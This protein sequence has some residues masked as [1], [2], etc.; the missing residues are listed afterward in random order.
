MNRS[1]NI[2]LL[3]LVAMFLVVLLHVNS[4]GGLL[5]AYYPKSDPFCF[6]TVN[7]VEYISLIAVNSYLFISGYFLSASVR[8]FKVGKLLHLLLTTVFWAWLIGGSAC[9]FLDAPLDDFL[10]DGIFPML[11][12]RYWFVTPYLILYFLSPYYNQTLQ[13]LDRRAHR[14]LLGFLLFF[15]SL[16]PLFWDPLGLKGGYS[17]YWFSF[18][19]ILA[20]YIRKYPV[21]HSVRTLLLVW[22]G[23]LLI[24]LSGAYFL[25]LNGRYDL[26]NQFF[27][28]NYNS[29]FIL[30]NT[31]CCFLLFRSIRI[32]RGQALIRFLAPLTFGIYLVHIHPA[33]ASWIYQEFL[34][35]REVAGRSPWTVLV[36]LFGFALLVF[37]VSALLEYCRSRLFVAFRVEERIGRVMR[38]LLKVKE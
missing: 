22:A 25:K 35:V 28:Q 12:G 29:P 27:G 17:L 5:K 38:R 8:P 36:S 10:S 19:Y 21:R 18:I 13:R 37:C 24:Q 16:A 33:T 20:A 31:V 14:L 3:R 2:E 15:F 1:L 11:S 26:A 30:V 34:P 32:R 9:L 23:V 7:L 6:L 4:Y